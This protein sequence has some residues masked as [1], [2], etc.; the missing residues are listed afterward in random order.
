[1]SP[2]PS[3]AGG[4]NKADDAVSAMQRD[5]G[6]STGRIAAIQRRAA[7][8][9][10]SRAAGIRSQGAVVGTPQCVRTSYGVH[11]SSIATLGIPASK[12]FM[13]KYLSYNRVE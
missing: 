1:M 11:R 8:S 5:R 2:K 13:S 6:R 9:T 10:P 7:R 3:A 12:V 4:G